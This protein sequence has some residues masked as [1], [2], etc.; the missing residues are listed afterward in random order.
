MYSGECLGYGQASS[1]ERKY[2]YDYIIQNKYTSIIECGT[3]EGGGTTYAV[4]NALK[5]QQ[6]G[7]LETFEL[8]QGKYNI[9]KQKYNTDHYVNCRNENFIDFIEKSNEIFDMV[10]I[11]STHNIEANTK[12]INEVLSKIRFGGCLMFHDYDFS[13]KDIFVKHPLF[14]TYKEVKIF[15]ET[16]PNNLACFERII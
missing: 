12:I 8:D 13:Y 1:Q 6:C 15:T 3:M 16:A 5:D 4:Y 2:I 11:D 9:A 7:G 14:V 10:L